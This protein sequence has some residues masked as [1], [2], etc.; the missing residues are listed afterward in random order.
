MQPSGIPV[1]VDYEIVQ[2]DDLIYYCVDP[3]AVLSDG[4]RQ[5]YFR[6]KYVD[7][8]L[9]IVFSMVFKEAHTKHLMLTFTDVT[10]KAK[11]QSRRILLL[12]AL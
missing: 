5:N 4:S 9:L 7:E 12:L 10:I 3:E 8:N 6:T 2:G 1:D 11:M